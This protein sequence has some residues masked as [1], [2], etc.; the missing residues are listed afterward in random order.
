MSIKLL[1]QKTATNLMAEFEKDM[2]QAELT[3]HI[4]E[5]L[6]E[7]VNMTKTECDDIRQACCQSDQ[8]IAH[9][10]AH[11]IRHQE[12]IVMANLMGLR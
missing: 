5:L 8:D 3:K 11:D 7:V 1:A 6:V 12:D 2:N 4:E 10:I 9:K